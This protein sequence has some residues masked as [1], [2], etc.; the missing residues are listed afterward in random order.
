MNIEDIK[1]LT[2]NDL[3]DKLAIAMGWILE[4]HPEVN[5]TGQWMS[6]YEFG[7]FYRQD[8]TMQ[9]RATW[10]PC[11]NV[12]QAREA[13]AKAIVFDADLY[14]AYLAE[15]VNLGKSKK[16]FNAMDVGLLL[17]ATPRQIAEA[18]YLTLQEAQG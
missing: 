3:S 17:L 10:N 4:D 7:V 9:L 15:I 8:R 18:S 13:Q 1:Q 11:D 14:I 12:E 16:R 2:D 6:E 5:G